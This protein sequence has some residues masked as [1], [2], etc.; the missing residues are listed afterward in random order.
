MQSHSKAF[1]NGL[2]GKRVFL[3]GGGGK[4]YSQVTLDFKIDSCKRK[5]TSVSH[6]WA[7]V[8]LLTLELFLE[9]GYGCG[10]LVQYTPDLTSSSNLTG[11]F[12]F[13]CRWYLM[14]SRKQV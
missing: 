4:D 2:L 11:I 8:I 5:E 12:S 1:G 3:G 10:W 13:Y 9:D 7:A 6:Q 14:G